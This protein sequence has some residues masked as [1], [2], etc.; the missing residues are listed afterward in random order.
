[1][2]QSKL[3]FCCFISEKGK[4]RRKKKAN[5]FCVERMPNA[6]DRKGFVCW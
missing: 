1:M 6:C 3:Y 4:T 2:E 5:A